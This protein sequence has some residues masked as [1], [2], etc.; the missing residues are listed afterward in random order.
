MSI[1]QP[2]STDYL[3]SPDHSLSHRVF[4]NDN[5]APVQTICVDS[6]GKVGIG[7]T[8]PQDLLHVSRNVGNSSGGLTLE[9]IYGSGWGS[10]LGFTTNLSGASP[11]RYNTA[12]IKSENTASNGGGYIAF[13]TPTAGAMTT[14]SE[15]MRI[16]QGNVGIG[17]TAPLAKLHI[18]Q[19]TSDAAKPVIT[20]DQA[21]VSEEFIRFIGTSANG[22]LTQ[23][24]VEN[25]DVSTS[26]LQGWL[27][28]YV[29]DD[30]NQLADSSYFI[31][32]Y[33]L[34]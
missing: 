17:I 20:L 5:A 26:T 28:V 6:S 12:Q 16:I 1:Q 34:A 25:A 27:K 13:S 2:Q 14:V 4:A 29:Q 18:D 24:I 9:N 23:S 7:T 3:N 21:D 19:A 31:P 15:A 8:S 10:T 22:I 11:T 32:I 30:G 33:T